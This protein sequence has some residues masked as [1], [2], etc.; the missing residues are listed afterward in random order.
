[1][2]AISI[3]RVSPLLRN[4]PII[5]QTLKYIHIIGTPLLIGGMAYYLAEM[6]WQGP[7]AFFGD[8]NV[9]QVEAPPQPPPKN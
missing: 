8:D 5:D 6:Q 3:A 4:R 1:M 2:I 7:Q 9:V